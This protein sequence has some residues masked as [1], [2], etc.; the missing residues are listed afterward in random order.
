M[1]FTTGNTTVCW[2]CTLYSPHTMK[3]PKENGHIS[4]SLAFNAIEQPFFFFFF[5]FLSLF[6]LDSHHLFR[7]LIQSIQCAA[8]LLLCTTQCT[9]NCILS[10]QNPY[11]LW[12][13]D[14]VIAITMIRGMNELRKRFIRWAW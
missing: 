7:L 5:F 9:G 12:C 14:T 8:I 6:F 1:Q 4:I 10:L 3:M 13:Y 11:K 2:V